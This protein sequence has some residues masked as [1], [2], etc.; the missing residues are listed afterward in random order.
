MCVRE[1]IIPVKT[2]QNSS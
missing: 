1:E 2:V